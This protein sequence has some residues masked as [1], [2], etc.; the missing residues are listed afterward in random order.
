MGSRLYVLRHLRLPARLLQQEV[1]PRRG[2]TSK[3]SH[4]ERTAA[5]HREHG[6]H[7]VVLNKIE[8]VNQSIRLLQ[9]RPSGEKPKYSSSQANG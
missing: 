2:M 8:Q 6:M 7:T 5:D 4:E 9:L 3:T 1:I